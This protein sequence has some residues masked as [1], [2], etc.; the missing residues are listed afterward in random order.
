MYM[1]IPSRGS[2]LDPA[3]AAF[4][5]W[6][7][8]AAVWSLLAITGF[9]IR[10][11]IFG[12]AAAAFWLTLAIE[13]LAFALTSAAAI[14]HGRHFPRSAPA[15][16]TFVG[17]AV[18]CLTA[19][20]LLSALGLFIQQLFP[21]GTLRIFSGGQYRLGFL[22]YMGIFSIWTLIYFGV[23][24]ELAARNERISKMKAETRAVQ[25]ELEHLQR[26]V[27]PHFLFNALNTIV[28][29]IAERPAIAEEMT[30]RLAAYLRYSLDQHGRG[31]CTLGEEIDAA[32]TYVRIQALRFGTQLEYESEVDP[33]ALEVHVPHMTLQGLV[34]N[35][36]KHGMP[37]EHAAFLISVRV[38]YQGDALIIEVSNPGRLHAPDGL[39]PG[40]GL[41]NLCRRLALYYPDR[42]EFSLS[43]RGGHAVAR[44]TLRGTPVKP[45]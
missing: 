7:A 41:S 21:P 40:N 12:N 4:G 32:E 45:V 44:I 6:Q 38:R 31:T 2:R 18:L 3:G 17:A 14:L 43:E 35:A 29:E 20:A 8:Q 37:A 39:R 42:N 33:A 13:P 22:Y 11:A 1:N 28:A 24:A 19:S 26:Q 36:I 15:I 23:R 16:P 9:C 34:E 10:Y 5:F 25:L 30:R 27:E